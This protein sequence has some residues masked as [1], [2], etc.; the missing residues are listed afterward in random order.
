MSPYSFYRLQHLDHFITEILFRDLE[1][2]L[3]NKKYCGRGAQSHPPLSKHISI[4]FFIT[5]LAYG[6]D[7]S[8]PFLNTF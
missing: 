4:L 6:G 8:F 3:F 1:N 7:P 2:K 5:K